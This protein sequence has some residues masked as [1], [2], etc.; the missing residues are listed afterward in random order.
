MLIAFQYPKFDHQP[1][2]I[3]RRVLYYQ[4]NSNLRLRIPY[5][6]DC[7][8]LYLAWN[9]KPFKSTPTSAICNFQHTTAPT[10]HSNTYKDMFDSVWDDSGSDSSL[11]SSEYNL[12][13]PCLFPP[14]LFSQNLL[15]KKV[16]NIQRWITK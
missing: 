11:T 10:H 1:K 2:K 12:C 4:K 16:N 15:I 6:L 14:V 13:F 3:W 7:F 5:W 9:V 8:S